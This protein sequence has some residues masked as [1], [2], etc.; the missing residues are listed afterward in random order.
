MVQRFHEETGT[1]LFRQINC[2]LDFSDISPEA[3]KIYFHRNKAR[4]LVY[5]VAEGDLPAVDDRT[6]VICLDGNADLCKLRYHDGSAAVINIGDGGDAFAPKLFQAL[7]DLG[8]PVYV[9]SRGR[10]PRFGVSVLYG[11]R[12]GRLFF[13]VRGRRRHAEMVPRDHG[14]NVFKLHDADALPRQSGGSVRGF[15]PAAE[16]PG[17]IDLIISGIDLQ[18]AFEGQRTVAVS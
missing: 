11:S 5:G 2:R 4:L 12:C 8:L 3:A 1:F 15:L 7:V 13:S 18:T 17:E 10:L 6:E 16:R 14:R 9:C